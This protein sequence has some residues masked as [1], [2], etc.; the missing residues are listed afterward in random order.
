[1]FHFPWWR[2]AE[3]GAY[4]S[5]RLQGAL[6]VLVVISLILNLYMLRE[7]LIFGSRLR[8]T[9]TVA[10][11]GLAQVEAELEALDRDGIRIPVRVVQ[12]MPL[13]MQLPLR[14]TVL[15]PISAT[16]P[17]NQDIK[18]TI[19]ADVLGVAVPVEVTVPLNLAIPVDLVVPVTI[20]E[21]VPISTSI[22]IDIQAPIELSGTDMGGLTLRLRNMLQQLK[23]ALR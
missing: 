10:Q 14:Q 3:K 23:D 16:I 7:W 1:M 19:S 5:Q 17:V 6:L 13:R 9:Q 11:Q 15:V 18:T 21:T 2:R 20:S 8:A 12:E 22:P 4:V